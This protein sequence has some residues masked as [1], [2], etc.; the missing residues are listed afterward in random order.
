[1]THTANPT[2]LRRSAALTSTAMLIAKSLDA[3][4]TAVEHNHALLRQVISSLMRPQDIQPTQL[5]QLSK[6]LHQ[7]RPSQLSLTQQEK[8]SLQQF[9]H[10]QVEPQE[11]EEM[12]SQKSKLQNVNSIAMDHGLSQGVEIRNSKC[13]SM[14]S[15]STSMTWKNS[16]C[17]VPKRLKSYLI[18]TIK[19]F[20]KSLISYKICCSFLFHFSICFLLKLT[21]IYYKYF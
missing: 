7:W 12:P 17:E 21:I 13:N 14:S 3:E 2:G 15:S 1:M 6:L 18:R 5:S 20:N 9:Q 19:F 10:C 4:L 8:K 16:L 11:M